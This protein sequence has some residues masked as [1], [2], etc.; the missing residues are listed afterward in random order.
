MLPTVL[1]WT[2]FHFK[3]WPMIVWQKNSVLKCIYVPFPALGGH[4]IEEN[5]Q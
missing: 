5:L 2:V 4:S 1:K 3:D